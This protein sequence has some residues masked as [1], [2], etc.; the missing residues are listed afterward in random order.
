MAKQTWAYR[1]FGDTQ[2]AVDFLNAAPG[3]GNKNRQGAGEATGVARS[4]GQVG[5]FY[6]EPGSLGSSTA[7]AWA[8]QEFDASQGT[9]GALDFLNGAPNSRNVGHRQGFGEA[10]LNPRNNGTVGLLYLEPGSLGSSTAPTWVFKNFPPGN[11]PG[12]GPGGVTF[13]LNGA[14]RQGAGQVSAMARN[15]GK[16]QGTDGSVGVFAMENPESLGFMASPEWLYRNFTASE[17]PQGA[18]DFL[19]ADPRKDPG[20]AT[21]VARSDGTVGLFYLEH[22]TG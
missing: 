10:S 19:N 8:Y 15:D 9:Q 3:S 7:Q 1:N 13:D 6:L 2:A 16:H 22:G 18:V 17:G 4:N 21:A 20:E 5:L 12:K 14:P 11:G